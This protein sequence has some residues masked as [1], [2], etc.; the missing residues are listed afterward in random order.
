MFPENTK[1]SSSAG[2]EEEDFFH[3]S[4]IKLISQKQNHQIYPP[5]ILYPPYICFF[6]FRRRGG[7][8]VF[9]VRVYYYL[10]LLFL[11]HIFLVFRQIRERE[12]LSIPTPLFMASIRFQQAWHVHASTNVDIA[13]PLQTNV[14]S[15][16][17]CSGG[18]AGFYTIHMHIKNP[19]NIRKH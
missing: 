10:L 3:Y 2:E 16:Q 9:F 14:D 19:E 12:V 18:N 7:R 4:L 6:F 17:P 5:Q 11:K 1:K 8:R 13:K 15:N